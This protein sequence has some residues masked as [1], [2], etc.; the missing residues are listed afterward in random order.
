MVHFRCQPLTR[1]PVQ[2]LWNFSEQMV[3]GQAFLLHCH[4][5]SAADIYFFNLL[6]ILCNFTDRLSVLQ[7]V[8]TFMG[9]GNLR[10]LHPRQKLEFEGLNN[11]CLFL[12][13]F[14]VLM[15]LSDIL[16]F[17]ITIYLC[18]TMLLLTYWVL[19][20]PHVHISTLANND[21]HTKSNQ[22]VKTA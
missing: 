11:F 21:L 8:N 4:S 16:T 12:Q 13:D 10:P 2:S 17:C 18:T 15:K 20:W 14:I 1:R 7:A 9:T 22:T 19:L 3:L 6:L 5:N